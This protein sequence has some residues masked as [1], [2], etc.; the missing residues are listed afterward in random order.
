VVR[1]GTIQNFGYGVHLTYTDGA[2]LEG[3]NIHCSY[4]SVTSSRA[5]VTP[6]FV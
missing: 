2:R 1:N 4:S 6:P 5:H 3:L